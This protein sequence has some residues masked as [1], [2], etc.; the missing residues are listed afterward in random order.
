ME[1]S[2]NKSELTHKI[3]TIVGIVLCAILTPILILNCVMLVQSW[4]NKDKV[5]NVFGLMPLIVY[6]DSMK[7]NNKDSFN[8]GDII[9]CQVVDA[10]TI[11][12]GDVIAF[13]DPALNKNGGSAIT[14][15]R[16]KAIET[17]KVGDKNVIQFTTQGD[18]NN[19]ADFEPVPE[20]MLVGKY[21]GFRLPGAGHVALFMQEWYGL[22]ICIGVPVAALVAYEIIRYQRENKKQTKDKDA[23][24]KELEE[25]RA[26]QAAGNGEVAETPEVPETAENTTTEE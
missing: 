19:I 10:K 14:T 2:T 22:V 25:L 26:L 15:H 21:T 3:L 8:S 13:F 24:L 23:L 7:G 5:P 11:K 12:E 4:V 17:V 20:S 1:K 9:Y 6:T 18:A 16:V